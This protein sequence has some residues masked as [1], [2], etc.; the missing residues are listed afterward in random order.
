M[1]SVSYIMRADAKEP[2][3][4]RILK[5]FKTII[6]AVLLGRNLDDKERRKGEKV[7]VSLVGERVTGWVR[8]QPRQ[9]T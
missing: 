7:S 3:K 5:A 1:E 8:K 6:L 9:R 4:E 2:S